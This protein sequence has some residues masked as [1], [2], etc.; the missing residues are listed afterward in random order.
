ME[1]D[2]MRTKCVRS[3]QL[4]PYFELIRRSNMAPTINIAILITFDF[5]ILVALLKRTEFDR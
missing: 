2:E 1:F 4:E 3:F 5:R